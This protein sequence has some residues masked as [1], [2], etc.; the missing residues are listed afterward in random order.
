MSWSGTRRRLLALAGLSAVGSL[1]RL[2]VA[3]GATPLLSRFRVGNG[4]HPFAGDR[5]NLTTLGPSS[6]RTAAEL[7]FSLARP[8]VVTLDVLQ[9]GQGAASEKAVAVGQAELS[10]QRS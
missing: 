6:G 8:S 9:T 1:G 5:I 10:A 3:L 7:K 2:P 4:G